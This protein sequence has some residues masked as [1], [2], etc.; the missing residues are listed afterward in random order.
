MIP[1]LIFMVCVAFCVSGA[2]ERDSNFACD[3]GFGAKIRI[4]ASR[5]QWHTELATLISEKQLQENLFAFELSNPRP[6]VRTE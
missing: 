3:S 4:I 5:K 2:R 6:A 1:V